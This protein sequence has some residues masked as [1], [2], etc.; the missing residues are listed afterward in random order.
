MSIIE[1][2]VEKAGKN[3]REQRNQLKKDCLENK[4]NTKVNA[5]IAD[6][7]HKPVFPNEYENLQLVDSVNDETNT[8]TLQ[9]TSINRKK[10]H[11]Q[12]YLSFEDSTSQL[13]EEFRM[14]KR[15]LI[16]N[17]MNAHENEISRANLILVT[18]SQPGEGKT[19]TAINLAFSIASERDKKVLLIDADVAQPSV[20]KRLDINDNGHGL[21]DYLDGE[22]LDFSEMVIKTDIDGLSI[23]PAGRRHGYSTELLASE[24][25]TLLADELHSR[26][27]DR[28]VIFDSPPLLATTQAE[29]LAELVGQ[30]VLVVEA[31]N[32]LQSMVSDSMNKLKVCDVVLAVLNKSTH[33]V[34]LNY[35]NYY[36]Q[37]GH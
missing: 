22:D 20:S 2:G 10:L 1:K 11:E 3:G 6:S 32:T 30:V 27:S 13:S 21:I 8:N 4:Q 18:S 19:F 9:F 5:S 24:R 26:Y 14:I 34:G 29:V 25:M 12:G 36:G 31:E 37:Y 16:N 23:I 28:I 7:F 15:P 17:V 35:H 33:T